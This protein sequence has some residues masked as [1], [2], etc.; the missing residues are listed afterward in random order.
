M[1]PTRRRLRLDMLCSLQRGDT[2]SAHGGDE[3]PRPAADRG[4]DS[5]DPERPSDAPVVHENSE[6]QRRQK[7][8][9]DAPAKRQWHSNQESD[10]DVVAADRQERDPGDDGDHHEENR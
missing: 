9:K 5:R 7:C 1:I 3:D 8:Q 4:R 6:N 2:F 10:Q